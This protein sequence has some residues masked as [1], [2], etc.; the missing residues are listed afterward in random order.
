MKKKNLCKSRHTAE[1][2]VGNKLRKFSPRL[3]HLPQIVLTSI[4]TGNARRNL[5]GASF[6]GRLRLAPY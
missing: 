3:V 5:T 2:M 1:A 4:T 6:S